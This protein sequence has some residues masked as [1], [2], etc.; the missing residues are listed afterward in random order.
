MN[1]FRIND[2]QTS[3]V[4]K[5]KLFLILVSLADIFRNNRCLFFYIRYDFTEFIRGGIGFD[6]RICLIY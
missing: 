1:R 2:Q 3:I 5:S 6:I 4:F